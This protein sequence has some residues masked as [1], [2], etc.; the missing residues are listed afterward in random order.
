[1][2][3]THINSILFSP[4]LN[5]RTTTQ[6]RCNYHTTFEG[7]K[8]LLLRLTDVFAISCPDEYTAKEIYDIIGQKLQ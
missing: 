5:F 8:F 6:D 2:W 7:F 4:E 3:E 1:M